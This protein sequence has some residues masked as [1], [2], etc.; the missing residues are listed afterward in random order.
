[1]R[2]NPLTQQLKHVSYDENGTTT[3]QI[4]LSLS[5]G[6]ASLPQRARRSEEL[7]LFQTVAS[8]RLHMLF[9]SR[10]Q[11]KAQEGDGGMADDDAAFQAKLGALRTEILQQAQVCD[12]CVCVCVCGFEP[13]VDSR[14]LRTQSGVFVL[15]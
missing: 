7:R 9:A 1:M 10:A 15:V 11:S 12:F 13:H 8:Q 6:Q 2:A 4:S 5:L 14:R 3:Q